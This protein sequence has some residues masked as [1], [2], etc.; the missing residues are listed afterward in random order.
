MVYLERKERSR[1]SCMIESVPQACGTLS[2]FRYGRI[3]K[4]N[5]VQN[6]RILNSVTLSSLRPNRNQILDMFVCGRTDFTYSCYV[7]DI[8]NTGKGSV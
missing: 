6:L 1:K 7:C 4:V 8:F 3:A 2:V 5:Q